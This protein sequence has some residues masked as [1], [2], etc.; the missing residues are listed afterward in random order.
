MPVNLYE[1]GVS[2]DYFKLPYQELLETGALIQDQEDKARQ[3]AIELGKLN[4]KF[5]EFDRP[6][7]LENKKWLDEQTQGLYTKAQ[8]R[9]Y[10]SVAPD[11][12]RLKIEA[13]KRFGD[14]FSAKAA[15]EGRLGEYNKY[16]EQI[17]KEKL[18][19][20][21]SAY[22]KKQLEQQVDPTTG[23]NP[24]NFDPTTGSYS[25]I[26]PYQEYDHKDLNKTI[27]DYAKDVDWDQI[28]KEGGYKSVDQFYREAQ[29]GKVSTKSYNKLIESLI[30]RIAADANLLKTA[31]VETE[32]TGG[33]PVNERSVILGVDKNG[34]YILNPDSRIASIV[35]GVS[36][37]ASFTR[38]DKDYR[39][40]QDALGL[41]LAKRGVQ[42]AG[43]QMRFPTETGATEGTGG[44]AK[45]AGVDQYFN[46]DG[47][48]KSGEKVTVTFTDGSK[49]SY[50]GNT[51]FGKGLEEKSKKGKS[52]T[53][54][55]RD[56]TYEFDQGNREL[57]KKANQLGLNVVRPDGTIDG[58]ATK[59]NTINYFKGLSA[60]SDYTVPFIDQNLVKNISE[61]IFGKMSNIHNMQIYEQGNPDSKSKYESDDE[62]NLLKGS[63]VIGLDY[64]ADNPGAMKFV[65]PTVN[66][67]VFSDNI[68]DYGDR[69]MIAISRNKTLQEQMRPVQELTNKS[70]KAARTGEKDLNASKITDI[71]R[72]TIV[73]VTDPY[74]GTQTQ[75]AIEDLGIPVAATRDPN[76]TIRISYLDNSSGIPI[77][78]VLEKTNTSVSVKSLEQVQEEKTGEIFN[79]GGAL[80]QYQK[81]TSKP[82]EPSVEFEEE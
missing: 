11:L 20:V 35:D 45:S 9:G 73:P 47:T 79:T 78:Q 52:P 3:G 80:S 28:V 31:E 82:T 70:I 76:G 41:Y 42:N 15:T 61:D 18:N 40:H 12:Q 71:L 36:R 22:Y 62:K 10:R 63:R 53:K 16:M 51:A 14:Q 74:S 37:G 1:Q 26:K 21:Q 58:R 69:P 5:L 7:A 57:F 29:Q 2:G 27:S 33:D 72:G 75:V 23:T 43:N 24:I 44:W 67:G 65:A 19:P 39:G 54:I 68:E 81:L 46:E 8:E 34:K 6:L 64:T 4:Q 32:M 38:E 13:N 56:P 55:E 25:H 66:R 30:P 50:V 17:G 77:I 60:Y 59:E 49:E 48:T